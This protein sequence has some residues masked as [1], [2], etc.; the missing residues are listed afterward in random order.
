MRSS[1][2]LVISFAAAT[3]ICSHASAA[4]DFILIDPPIITQK[5]ENSMAIAKETLRRFPPPRYMI[6]KVVVTFSVTSGL[7][8]SAEGK[9]P[10]GL[11]SIGFKGEY[12]QTKTT[13]Q[14]F[15]YAPAGSIPTNVEDFGV[16][17]FINQIQEKISAD[18]KK[19]D[20]IVTRAEYEQEFVI[21]ID[22]EGK[23]SFLSVVDVSGKADLKN[24]HKITFYFCLLTIEGKCSEDR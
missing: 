4:N 17:A 10:V 18:L 8:G 15:T 2:D 20:F 13:K 1:L 24:S 6:N 9:I 14:T 5:F 12:Q 21:G 7:D 11:L 16:L 3:L 19:K 23:I 22:G